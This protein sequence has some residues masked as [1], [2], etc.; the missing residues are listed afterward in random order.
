MESNKYFTSIVY[1]LILIS[2]SCFI[3]HK[4]QFYKHIDHFVEYAYSFNKS[5][6]D[7]VKLKDC[8]NCIVIEDKGSPKIIKEKDINVLFIHIPKNAGTWVRKTIPGSNGGH[9]HLSL[10]EIRKHYPELVE[11]CMT[12]AIVRN[13]W[14]RVVSMYNFHFNTNKMD[15]KGWGVYG[16]N[17]L[18]K[19]NVETFDEFVRLLFEHRDNIRGLGE[20]V[21]EKQMY[22]ITDEKNEVIVDKI[23][24]IENIHNE[25]KALIKENGIKKNLYSKKINVSQSEPYQSYYTPETKHLVELTYAEDI[26]FTGYCF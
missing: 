16:L 21:W 23:I 14:E 7:A 6:D 12:F 25:M 10:F 9:D 4:F 26:A 17:I 22:F 19:H 2:L 3:Q 20:I 13:P 1:I 11:Q 5:T 8:K 15:I 24:H 18:K